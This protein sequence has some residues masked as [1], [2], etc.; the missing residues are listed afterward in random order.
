[1]VVHANEVAD[2][3]LLVTPLNLASKNLF[4]YSSTYLNVPTDSI[5]LAKHIIAVILELQVLE[6]IGSFIQC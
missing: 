5:A 3:I 4:N 6:Q 2:S 1:M